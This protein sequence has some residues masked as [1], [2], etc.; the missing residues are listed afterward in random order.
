MERHLQDERE[1]VRPNRATGV[2]AVVSKNSNHNEFLGR[3]K[4]TRQH[5]IARKAPWTSWR[6][7]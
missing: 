6:R 4:Q 7:S 2:L 1:T 5:A 3:L